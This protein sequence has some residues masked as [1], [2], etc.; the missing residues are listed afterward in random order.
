MKNTKHLK[1]SKKGMSHKDI[2]AKYDGLP[3]N[4]LSTWIKNK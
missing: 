2:A 4:T 1:I 3:K